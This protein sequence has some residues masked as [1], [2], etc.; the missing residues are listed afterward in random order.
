MTEQQ[1]ASKAYARALRDF[2]DR[3]EE[4]VDVAPSQIDEFAHLDYRQLHSVELLSAAS[5]VAARMAK[6]KRGWT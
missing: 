4:I 1:T 5:M 2:K 3:K 6:I